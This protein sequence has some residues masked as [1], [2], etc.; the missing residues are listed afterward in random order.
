VFEILLNF[1]AWVDI[2]C[3]RLALGPYLNKVSKEYLDEAAK[4]LLDLERPGIDHFNK[5]LT[6]LQKKLK[7]PF[8]KFTK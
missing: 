4:P 2:N 8:T 7:S 3:L 6:Y 1:Q 5:Y